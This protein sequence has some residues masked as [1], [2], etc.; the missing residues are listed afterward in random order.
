MQAAVVEV[1]LAA[2]EAVVM[3]AAVVVAEVTAD[4]ELCCKER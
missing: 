1:M 4:L 2:V 3:Q